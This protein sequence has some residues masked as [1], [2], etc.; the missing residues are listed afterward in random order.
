MSTSTTPP[1]PIPDTPA[2]ITPVSAALELDLRDELRTRGVL[3]WLDKTEDFGDFV[4]ALRVRWQEGDFPYP[5]AAYRGS[6]LE[7]MLQ[8]DGLVEG[9]GNRPLLIHM[10]GFNYDEIRETPVLEHY[11]AG[12]VFRKALNTLVTEAAAGKV[13]PEE[14]A[15]FANRDGYGLADADKWLGEQ[16]SQSAG[17]LDRFS[18]PAL[19]KKLREAP[20]ELEELGDVEAHLRARLG[21][22]ATWQTTTGLGLASKSELADW[23][24]TW[25][26][27]VEYVDD[28]RRA[29]IEE[30]LEPLTDLPRTLVVECSE[31]AA[32][33]RGSAEDYYARIAGEFELLIGLESEKGRFEDLGDIDTFRFEELRYFEGALVALAEERW[34][35]AARWASKRTPDNS[36]WIRREPRRGDAWQLVAVAANFGKVLGALV[37]PFAGVMSLEEAAAR[38]AEDAWQVDR[39]HR[40]LEQRRATLLESSLPEFAAILERLDAMRRKYREW[41]NQLAR[42]F[43]GLCEA[44]GFLPTESLQQRRI[45]DQVVAPWV[46]DGGKVALFMVDGL[47]FEMAAELKEGFDESVATRTVLKPRLAELP[48]VTAVGMNVL[49]TVHESGRLKPLINAKDTFRGFQTSQFQVIT[50][51]DRRRMMQHH[52]GGR[53]CPM[54]ALGEVL[55]G[56]KNLRSVVQQASLVVVHSRA[57]DEVGEKGYGQLIYE[58]A[59]RDLRSAI[60]LLRKAGVS[61]F[62]ITSDHGFMMI[63][64]TVERHSH[65]KK[66]DPSPRWRLREH[67]E[68]SDTVVSVPLAALCYEDVTGHL[69]LLRDTSVFDTGAGLPNYV[70]GGGSPQERII[71]ALTVEYRRKVGGTTTDYNIVA[72]P[73]EGRGDIS[74]IRLCVKP[75]QATLD[76]GGHDEVELAIR[77]VGNP[78]VSVKIHRLDGAGRLD[79]S[80]VFV[81]VEKDAVVYFHLHGSRDQRVRVEVYAPTMGATVEPNVLPQWFDVSGAGSAAGGAEVEVEVEATGLEAL[82]EGPRKIFEY[83]AK[84]DAISEADAARVLGSTRELR[85]FAR[86]FEEYAGQVAFEV[87][88]EQTE[89]GK[90]YVR[91]K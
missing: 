86:S 35:E 70:H 22:A 41:S 73:V 53:H 32:Y 36:F 91:K 33:L 12:K 28:L 68:T 47:R 42:R 44:H 83:L 19:W 81:P 13:A 60:G 58:T 5:V 61:R 79:A 56:Q 57:I 1:N 16:M 45:F 65:G 69:L 62:V 8:L 52:V 50:P 77:A 89:S 6:F 48:S 37:D 67:P 87:V 64:Q 39:A 15:E 55:D 80:S 34:E 76:F 85:R 46:K 26:L 71:P 11:E 72:D 4:D 49:A 3:V 82:P 24:T 84:F 7:L 9:T 88:T 75:T 18:L 2:N 90:R 17:L 14:V 54:L 30:M 78:D 21:I 51:D 59:L 63:D 29:P 74:A 43:T 38:Y 23:M 27:A 40:V 10:P 25:A 31:F 66:T 20:G